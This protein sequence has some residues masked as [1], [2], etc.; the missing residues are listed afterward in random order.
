VSGPL[1][2]AV[3]RLSS[4]AGTRLAIG[5][6]ISLLRPPGSLLPF[7]FCESCL[8]SNPTSCPAGPKHNILKKLAVIEIQ[9]SLAPFSPYWGGQ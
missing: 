6:R 7:T 1:L 5:S 3:L 8:H 2:E 9:P 4:D